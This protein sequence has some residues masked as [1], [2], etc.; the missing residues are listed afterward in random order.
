MSEYGDIDSFDYNFSYQ[1]MWTAFDLPTYEGAAGLPLSA[2]L[3]VGTSSNKDNFVST[4][5]QAWADGKADLGEPFFHSGTTTFLKSADG[6][7]AYIPITLDFSFA[8]ERKSSFWYFVSQAFKITT[9]TQSSTLSSSG[10]GSTIR[11]SS[12]TS[13][14]SISSSFTRSMNSTPG[15]TSRLSTISLLGLSSE[16]IP[17]PSGNGVP[18]SSPS[19]P[20]LTRRTSAGMIAGVVVGVLFLLGT[21]VL[22]LFLLLKRKQGSL[23]QI[24]QGYSVRK[25]TTSSN[26][27]K[28]SNIV[29]TTVFATSSSLI[30]SQSPSHRSNSQKEE[31]LVRESDRNNLQTL[32]PHIGDVPP[33][34]YSS[35]TIQPP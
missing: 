28:G 14:S 24:V 4:E 20:G 9:P 1:L 19:T 2:R 30:V 16:V 13:S 35:I 11:A 17:R 10:F 5:P 32:P 18:V 33:P 6:N 3:T 23:W 34:A 26:L 15:L 22:V 31:N 25:A 8:T 7:I 21:I 27:Q 29:S 12:S